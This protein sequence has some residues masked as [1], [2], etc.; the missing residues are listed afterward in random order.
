MLPLIGDVAPAQAAVD[1]FPDLFR[2]AW[3]KVFRAKLGLQTEAEGDAE[4]IHRLMEIMT[5]GQSDFT[6]AFRELGTEMPLANG[7][8][9]GWI[10]LARR[11]Q[12]RRIE[13]T[14]CSA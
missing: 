11:T 3:L 14:T 1:R 2:Q 6:N 13:W 8:A 10:D 4:L 5:N 7:S 9:I 12:P